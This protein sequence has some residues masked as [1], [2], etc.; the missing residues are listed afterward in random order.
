MGDDIRARSV[1]LFES[2]ISAALTQVQGASAPASQI[3]Q[4][5]ASIEE[6]I[7]SAFEG[8]TGNEYRNEVRERSL[9]IKKD[10]PEVIK[11]LLNGE[12]GPRE[13]TSASASDLRSATQ[14]RTDTALEEQNLQDSLGMVTAEPTVAVNEDQEQGRTGQ[15]G[16]AEAMLGEEGEFKS[17][18]Q[19][20][21]GKAMEGIEFE[22]P[23]G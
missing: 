22:T 19:P 14:A 8:Q 5:A 11:R 16:P 2:S 9:V 1:S 17:R 21:V 13:F 20:K 7:F 3:E 18:A 10:N 15:V 4:L 23:G 6:A 12:L